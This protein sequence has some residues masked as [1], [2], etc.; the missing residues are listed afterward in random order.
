MDEYDKIVA[1]S[2]VHLGYERSDTKAFFTIY[3]KL[4]KME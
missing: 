4:S 1:L 2:N 3:K